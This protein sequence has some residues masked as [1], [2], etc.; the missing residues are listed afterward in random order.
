MTLSVMSVT[1]AECH[2]SVLYAECCYA[3]CCGAFYNKI[4][5]FMLVN[6]TWTLTFKTLKVFEITFANIDEILVKM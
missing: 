3:E 4:L 6:K 2:I 1:F 5:S